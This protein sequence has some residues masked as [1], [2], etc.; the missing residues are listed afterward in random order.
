MKETPQQRAER[1]DMYISKAMSMSMD[2]DPAQ[3]EKEASE[4]WDKANPLHIDHCTPMNHVRIV[5][6]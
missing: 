5:Q 6:H 1:K 3:V 4:T 2:A